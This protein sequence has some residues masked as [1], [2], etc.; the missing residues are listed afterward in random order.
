[1]GQFASTGRGKIEPEKWFDPA[2]QDFIDNGLIK[3]SKIHLCNSD[4][5][6]MSKMP[7]DL[8]DNLEASL[9]VPVILVGLKAR[10]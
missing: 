2:F 9:S 10:L 4:E 1:M 8:Q 3:Q 6:H 5:C 7:N